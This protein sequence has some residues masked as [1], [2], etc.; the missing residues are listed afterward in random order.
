MITYPGV[1]ASEVLSDPR[2][3]RQNRLH[4][5]GVD[6]EN[7]QIIAFGKNQQHEK[8][9]FP[10]HVHSLIERLEQALEL[11]S[12]DWPVFMTSHAP[13]LYSTLPDGADPSA[14]EPLELQRQYGVIPSALSTNS[15]QS[16]LKWLCEV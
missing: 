16:A 13:S 15:G 10:P 3:D 8:A 6:L 5:K 11:P 4:W 9:Q 14:D 7:N 2:D 1:R 12:S